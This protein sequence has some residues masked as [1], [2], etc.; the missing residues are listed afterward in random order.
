MP[1]DDSHSTRQTPMNLDDKI[2]APIPTAADPLAEALAYTKRSK[3]DNSGTLA[4][5]K[6]AKKAEK[7]PARRQP[8][9]A[10]V[11]DAPADNGAG[12]ANLVSIKSDTAMARVLATPAND[13]PI[14]QP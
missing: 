1:S 7:A 10:L 6:K 2:N 4:M 9:K 3:G 8:K 11:F 5:P 13:T 12:L 14:V